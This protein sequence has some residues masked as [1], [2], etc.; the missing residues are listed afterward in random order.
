[1][2]SGLSAGRQAKSLE[3]RGLNDSNRDW[4]DTVDD[5]NPALP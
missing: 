2:A 4:R 5:I 3:Y 1:M